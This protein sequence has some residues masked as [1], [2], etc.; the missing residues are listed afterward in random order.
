M[1]GD[2]PDNIWRTPDDGLRISCSSEAINASDPSITNTKDVM[3]ITRK[4]IADIGAYEAALSGTWM[5]MVTATTRQ[6][7]YRLRISG[8]GYKYTG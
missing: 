3:G 1:D 4:G 2:G 5:P 6:R 7:R 8:C